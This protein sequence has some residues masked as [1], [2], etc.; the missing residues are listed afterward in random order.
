MAGNMS[1]WRKQRVRERLF[2]AQKGKC[3]YCERP[4]YLTRHH[5]HDTFPIRT[6]KGGLH[7]EYR[8]TFEHL[9]RRT[10]G[11]TDRLDN[12]A[13]A[14]NWCNSRR[15]DKTWLEFKTEMADWWISAA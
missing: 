5:S 4:I 10:D 11:G 2:D 6:K 15:G 7:W 3:C 13:L 12:L 14:C 9:K 1:K 8:G